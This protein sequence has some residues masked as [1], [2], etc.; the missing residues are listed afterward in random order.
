MRRFAILCLL[1]VG[2]FTTSGVAGELTVCLD[3]FPNPNHVPLYVA[4][5]SGW[6]SEA[7]LSVDIVIPANVSDPL[8][9]VA[10]GRFDVALTPQINYM[11]ALSE[12]LP[13]QCIGALIDRNLGG[14]LARGGDGI[15]TLDDLRGLRI[16]YSLAPLEPVLWTTMLACAGV[17]IDEVTLVNVGYNT[18]VSLLSGAVDAIGAFRNYER[19]QVELLGEEAVFFP[20]EEHC[21]PDTYDI[22]LV[23][24]RDVSEGAAHDLRILL[25]VL[26]RAV[27]ATLERPDE[28]Y[29]LFL[30][31]HPDL[32]DELNRGS[33]EATLP[34]YAAGLRHD[35]PVQWMTLQDYLFHHEL[36]GRVFEPDELLD[37]TFLPSRAS[38]GGGD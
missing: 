37:A 32:D 2:L 35:D 7:G 3:F 6:F 19:L 5:E 27:D 24:R 30:A 21:V 13:L 33:F 11:I 1:L 4:Q 10:A 31:A 9:L 17:G 28:A 22:T 34:L 8:K 15:T 25:E 29:A 20:Q 16:G 26:A 38:Q 36:I 23:V 12:G 14:L 18:V